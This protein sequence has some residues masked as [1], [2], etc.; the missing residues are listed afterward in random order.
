MRRLTANQGFTLIELIAILVIVAAL[1][2]TVLPRLINQSS[3][4]LQ[5]G[6]D[7]LVSA[8]L[9]AQQ[10]AMTRTSAVT[11]SLQ[12][13]QI[14][15]QADGVSQR[16]GDIQFPLSLSTGLSLSSHSFTFDRLG[17]TQAANITLSA[18]GNSL[19]ITVSEMGYAQ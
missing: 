8:F 6:R 10:L 4:Q 19:V 14:D 17:R 15:V 18:G 5:S 7:T 2:A 13:N 3:F 1:G 11:L 9:S 12:A 16:L